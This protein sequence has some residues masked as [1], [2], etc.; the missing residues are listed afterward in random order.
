VCIRSTDCLNLFIKKNKKELEFVELTNLE[1]SMENQRWYQTVKIRWKIVYI[2]CTNSPD[3]L[4]NLI[5]FKV[6]NREN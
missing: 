5:S 4:R 1:N 6:Q 3:L 2:R